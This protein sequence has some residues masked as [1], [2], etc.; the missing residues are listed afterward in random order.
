M[1]TMRGAFAAV[2]DEPAAPA[3][4]AAPLAAAPPAAPALA[5]PPA[6]PAAPVIALASPASPTNAAMARLAMA[7]NCGLAARR[8]AAAAMAGRGMLKNYSVG[9]SARAIAM[10]ASSGESHT[11]RK[12][13]SLSRGERDSGRTASRTPI[14]TQAAKRRSARSRLSQSPTLAEWSMRPRAATP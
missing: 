1:L 5:A 10:F 8:A 4:A 2:A 9:T 13:S 6:L 11:A 14:A 3:P 12:C 7:A